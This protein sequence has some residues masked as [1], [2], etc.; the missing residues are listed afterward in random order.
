MPW[1]IELY[2]FTPHFHHTLKDLL[3]AEWEVMSVLSSRRKIL[4]LFAEAVWTR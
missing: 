2:L 4:L 1:I 3:K